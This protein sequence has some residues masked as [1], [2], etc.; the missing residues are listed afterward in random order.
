MKG[1]VFLLYS[2]WN[3][4][5]SPEENKL[6]VRGWWW[7]YCTLSS[8]ILKVLS[9]FQLRHNPNPSL[10][11]VS[12]TTDADGRFVFLSLSWCDVV[13]MLIVSC[14]IC[15]YS[16][17]WQWFIIMKKTDIKKHD[18]STNIYESKTFVQKA[19]WMCDSTV[20]HRVQ[21]WWPL[22][23]KFAPL[24]R[25]K[26]CWVLDFE[27]MKII[28]ESRL[29][30]AA[31]CLTR[32]ASSQY[33]NLSNTTYFSRTHKSTVQGPFLMWSVTNYINTYSVSSQKNIHAER[34]TLT[35]LSR[36]SDGKQRSVVCVGE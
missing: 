13:F 31:C 25:C 33:N 18:N 21:L 36:C 15:A 11:S 4:T 22:R 14:F 26:K 12:R 24:T 20:L 10:L 5:P 3:Y 32:L 7:K 6:F 19:N 34:T 8:Y 2:V 16:Q 35:H 1:S 27:E 28:W 30:E 29:K 23:H 9:H 17:A